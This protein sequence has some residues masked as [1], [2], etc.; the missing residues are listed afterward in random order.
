MHNY[1]VRVLN[2]LEKRESASLTE[3]EEHSKLGKDQVLWALHGLESKGFATLRYKEG[4]KVV[5]TAEGR[6]YAEHGLPESRLLR[7]ISE[8]GVKAGS[9]DSEED[10]I[11]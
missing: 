8:S 11:G 2:L 1:E 6:K 10:R 3:L 9:L 7:R 5:L 4:Q